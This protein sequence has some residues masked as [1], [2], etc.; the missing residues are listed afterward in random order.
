[1]NQPKKDVSL[2]IYP[3]GWHN[4]K[5]NYIEAKTKQVKQSWLMNW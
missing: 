5:F 2:S 1:M 4:Y 3:V